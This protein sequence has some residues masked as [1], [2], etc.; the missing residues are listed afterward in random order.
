VAIASILLLTWVNTLGISAG[1]SIQNVFT[2]TK[3]LVLLGMI[4]AG[5]FITSNTE[6]VKLNKEIFWDAAKAGPGG[7]VSLTGF[8][9]V[10]GIVTAMVGSLFSSDAWNNITFASDEVIKP[11]RII[12]LSLLFGTLTV[13]VLYL[14]VNVAYLQ[15][16]PLRGAADGLTVAEKG[17]QYAVDDRIGTA[18]MHGLLGENAALIM[19]ILIMISTFGCNN[20]II[21]SGARIFYAM[22]VDGLFFSKAGV[23]N[24]HGV[25][26]RALVFQ[27]VYASL[28]CLSG[29][30][31]NLLD[32]VIFTVLLFYI[33]SIVAVFIFR[34]KIPHAPRAYKAVG[35]PVIPVFYVAVV[36]FIM[37][38]LAVYKPL[39]TWPGLIIVALGVPVYFIWKRKK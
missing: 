9:I 32:Y 38:I 14:L 7:P 12:P 36:V 28:L 10:A 17:M 27:G 37:I 11:H 25:P 33:L 16:I 29:T 2:S 18:A 31:S 39:Y 20:G 1:K 4:V 24:S 26:G 22:A 30:Y 15:S 13:S 3:M 21:L 5:I 19:A 8:A 35:Y 34:K 23:L 6:A